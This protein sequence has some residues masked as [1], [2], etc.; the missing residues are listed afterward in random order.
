MLILVIAGILGLVVLA[1]IAA[2]SPKPDLS[3]LLL[4]LLTV[5]NLSVLSM[6]GLLLLIF[7]VSAPTDNPLLPGFT[8]QLA[9]AFVGP[10]AGAALWGLLAL[11]P[12]VRHFLAQFTPINPDSPV[13][14]LAL[15]LSGYLIANTLVTL[16][17]GGVAE[18]AESADAASIGSLLLTGLALLAAAFLG[19]GLGTRRTWAEVIERLG[20]RPLRATDW[21]VIVSGTT[22]LLTMEIGITLLLSQF[23]PEQLAQL[24]NVNIALLS[25][26]DSVGEWLVLGLTSGVGEEI[27]FRGALQPA[28]GIWPT[29]ILFA[30]AHVQ[31]DL[32]PLMVFIFL[33]G[34]VLGVI[35]QRYGTT[36]AILVHFSYNFTLGLFALLAESI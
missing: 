23:Y 35:R 20:L 26:L 6:A 17:Q 22:L 27:L 16:N 24:E 32:S 4:A 8:P 33:L 36:T 15:V 2:A 18:L 31:Y 19:V 9:Q 29:A 34:L 14:M 30:V 11:W 12:R 21:R 5:L 3:R 7:L 1:N 28:F 10:L 13:H 25:D